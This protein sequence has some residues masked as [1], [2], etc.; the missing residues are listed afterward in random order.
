VPR[1]PAD[2]RRRHRRTLLRGAV[3]AT[4]G[5]LALVGTAPSASAHNFGLRK[6]D[7]NVVTFASDE[8]NTDHYLFWN[9]F[10]HF[11]QVDQYDA[12]TDL[13][14]QERGRYQWDNSTDVVWFAAALEPGVNADE[15]CRVV[16][17]VNRR[18]DRARV[19]FGEHL[20]N[21]PGPGGFYL[22]CHEFGHAYGLEHLDTG[23]RGCMSTSANPYDTG[24]S[25]VLSNHMIGHINAE[26]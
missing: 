1:T 21:I 17:T 22:A 12:R 13:A 16:N 18:C 19:R 5:L 2:T 11:Q 4:V 7:N 20:R 26:Y 3:T 23:D 24:L 15:V 25:G 9:H 8:D 10:V 14:V 6:T